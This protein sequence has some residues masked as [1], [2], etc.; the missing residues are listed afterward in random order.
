M[1]TTL[2]AAL[3][4]AP[5]LWATLLFDLLD[6]YA[7]LKKRRGKLDES[8]EKSWRNRIEH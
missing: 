8:S 7:A 6:L 2:P 3:G 5:K 1:S 4:G